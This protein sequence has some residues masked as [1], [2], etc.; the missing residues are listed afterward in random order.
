M[1]T[2]RSILVRVLTLC[3]FFLLF[4]CFSNKNYCFK[5][6]FL[7]LLLLILVSKNNNNLFWF[8]S[9]FFSSSSYFCYSKLKNLNFIF[10]RK[11]LVKI[12]FCAIEKANYKHT[13]THTYSKTQLL[14]LF[15]FFV[16]EN[17][18]KEKHLRFFFYCWTHF[19]LYFFATNKINEKKKHGKNWD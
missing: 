3:M 10:F 4:C 14:L 13:H 11:F 1:P 15:L 17:L 8:G 7:L 6:R 12:Y 9:V 5:L 16:R 2:Q 18:N 19:R